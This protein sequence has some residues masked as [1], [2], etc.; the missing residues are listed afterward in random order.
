ML[1]MR[2]LK[3]HAKNLERLL[4]KANISYY[5]KTRRLHR[6]GSFDFVRFI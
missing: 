4:H 6:L 1:L 5:E 3:Q 2:M